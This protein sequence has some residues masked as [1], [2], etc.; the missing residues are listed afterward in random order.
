M[1][2]INTILLLFII[3]IKSISD[4]HTLITHS[5]YTHTH[6]LIIQTH[7]H[8]RYI[9]DEAHLLKLSSSNVILPSNINMIDKISKR[10]ASQRI[11]LS[12]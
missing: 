6:T 8:Y 1:C 2:H 5:S 4:T 12:L 10:F 9:S 11:T 3:I 7:T